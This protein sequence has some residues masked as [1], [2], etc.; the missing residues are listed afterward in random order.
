MWGIASCW[1]R[2]ALIGWVAGGGGA[3]GLLV[4]HAA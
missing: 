3:A 4:A 1:Q 2:V